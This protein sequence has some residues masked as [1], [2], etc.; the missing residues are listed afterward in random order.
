M[1]RSVV[2]SSIPLRSYVGRMFI[3]AQ[4]MD[5]PC[6]RKP[7]PNFVFSSRRE[8]IRLCLVSLFKV[9]QL[10]GATS[11]SLISMFQILGLE[12]CTRADMQFVTRHNP[13]TITKLQERSGLYVDTSLAILELNR[14]ARGVRMPSSWLAQADSKI[15]PTSHCILVPLETSCH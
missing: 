11:A 2:I 15:I 3:T 4:Y 8:Y 10:V 7:V 9:A 6:F 12:G 13:R 5:M 1:R 14:S